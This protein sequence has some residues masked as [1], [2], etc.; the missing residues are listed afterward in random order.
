MVN[1]KKE[2]YEVI[3]FVV[4]NFLDILEYTKKIPI[5]GDFMNNGIARRVFVPFS[6]DDERNTDLDYATKVISGLLPIGF[7]V[8]PE[9]TIEDLKYVERMLNITVLGKH[10]TFRANFEGDNTNSRNCD[11]SEFMGRILFDKDEIER[12]KNGIT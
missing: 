7:C 4:N 5:T 1:N 11:I 9:K 6:I 10:A 3:A 8:I 2:L 12:K